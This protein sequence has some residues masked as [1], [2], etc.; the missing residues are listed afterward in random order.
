MTLYLKYSQRTGKTQ[1][2]FIWQIF[3]DLLGTEV[4]LQTN[5][6][7][8]GGL[9]NLCKQVLTLSSSSPVWLSLSSVSSHPL[10]HPQQSH[11]FKGHIWASQSPPQKLSVVGFHCCLQTKSNSWTRCLG[12]FPWASFHVLPSPISDYALSGLPEGSGTSGVQALNLRGA[13]CS[14]DFSTANKAH[15]LVSVLLHSS[16]YLKCSCP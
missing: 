3:P 4:P 2:Y 12:L 16:L 9:E 10:I 13:D 5:F 14:N 8:G 6:P 15:T 1:L 7:W 11:L